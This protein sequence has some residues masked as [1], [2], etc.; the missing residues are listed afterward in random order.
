MLICHIVPLNVLPSS[1]IFGNYIFE[2]LLNICFPSNSVAINCYLFPIALFILFVKFVSIIKKALGY[3]STGN[4]RVSVIKPL[5]TD[6]DP[7]SVPELLHFYDWV[8]L[9]KL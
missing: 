2:S 5:A 3:K 9:C 7:L 6:T 8:A 4:G 1:I